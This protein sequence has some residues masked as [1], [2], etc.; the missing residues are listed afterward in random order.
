MISACKPWRPI[1]L[2][3]SKQTSKKE[4]EILS[5]FYAACL[6]ISPECFLLGNLSERVETTGSAQR[7]K[8]SLFFANSLLSLKSGSRLIQ[9]EC[10]LH[11]WDRL[12]RNRY[13][14]VSWTQTTSR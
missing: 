1:Q 13:E 2:T 7:L 6:A 9:T 3:L 4:P 14:L 10:V 8:E 12:V 5:S 11:I